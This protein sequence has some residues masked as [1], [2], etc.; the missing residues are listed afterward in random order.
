MARLSGSIGVGQ[1]A[2]IPIGWQVVLHCADRDGRTAST[3]VGWTVRVVGSEGA[4]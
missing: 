1:N 4:L 3:Y 2:L